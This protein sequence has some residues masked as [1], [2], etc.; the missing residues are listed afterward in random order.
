M[1]CNHIEKFNPRENDGWKLIVTYK[2][3]DE[4]NFVGYTCDFCPKCG[5]RIHPDMS[6]MLKNFDSPE[7]EA[8]ENGEESN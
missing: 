1:K 4:A 2:N 6:K 5:E 3:G 7:I 8:Y